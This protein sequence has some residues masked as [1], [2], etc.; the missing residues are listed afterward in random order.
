MYGRKSSPAVGAVLSVLSVLYGFAVWLRLAACQ[1]GILR[2][3]R[4]PFTVISVGNITLG[5]TGKTPVVIH[6]AD[7][8]RRRG[9]RPAVL[10][11]GYGR[12]EQSELVV[13]S[14]GKRVLTDAATGGD[15]P[16]L[17]G[18][19]LPGVPVLVGSD[20]YRTGKAAGEGFHADVA[21]LD[22]GFQHIRLHRDLNI[23]LVDGT[24]PFGNGKLFPAGTL[25]EPVS[26]LSR[27]D[28]VIITRADQTANIDELRR[29]IGRSTKAPVFTSRH[30]PL[31]LTDAATGESR[32]L[33][34][35]RGA[36]VV[37]CCGIARPESFFTLLRSLGS[38]VRAS[39]SF[40]DHYAYARAD[41]AFLYQKAV[42]CGAA[43]IVT[44]EKDAVRLRQMKTERIWALRI[45]AKVVEKDEWEGVLLRY[46]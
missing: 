11:R 44:T 6:I 38:D 24:A 27:A 5:G 23:V 13:V 46:V 28:A 16:L 31:D 15:E 20:R 39:L 40:S 37:A 9:R 19:R 33:A 32:P 26:S 10:S 34:A 22:D 17:M 43:M 4:L 29:L 7:E 35:L 14:D 3:R 18:L 12:S 45:E 1:A 21:V 25:R 36:P 30:V 41:L 2:R 42:D 8:L